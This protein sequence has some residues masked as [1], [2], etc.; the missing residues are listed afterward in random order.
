MLGH[1]ARTCENRVLVRH[2]GRKGHNW[3]RRVEKRQPQREKAYSVA[4]EAVNLTA[5][6]IFSE[7]LSVMNGGQ[8]PN[9]FFH[10]VQEFRKSGLFTALLVGSAVATI[11]DRWDFSYTRE[12]PPE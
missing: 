4:S 1:A 5:L 7:R 9:V 3:R 6:G 11:A 8:A 12:I 2:D 10:E